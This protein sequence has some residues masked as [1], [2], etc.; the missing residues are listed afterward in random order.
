MLRKVKSENGETVV[1]A[2]FI[3]PI[4]I[5]II[6]IMMYLGFILYQQTIM[7]V[8]ANEVSASIGQ[9][10]ATPSKDPF[11]GFTE[12][13]TLSKTKLYRN[14]HNAIGNALGAADTVDGSNQT[15]GQW[16]GK[17]R[18]ASHCL[19]EQTGSMEVDVAFERRSGT[20]LQKEVVVKIEAVYDLPFL[21]FFGIQ[22]S[23]KR[24]TATGRA[25]C[26]DL[27]DY[28]STLSLVNTVAD[29]T[30]KPLAEDVMEAIEKFKNFLG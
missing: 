3:V 30:L 17:Y 7:T 27:L 29:D 11:T 2:T 10:Y 15:K 22:N 23:Q 8:V 28:A 20:L 5:M 25:Q 21:R 9:V 13:E 16:F 24:F 4:V 12:T 14:L 26:Q 18:M 1:E 6:F 19:Y